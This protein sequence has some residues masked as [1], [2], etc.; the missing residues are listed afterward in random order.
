MALK[1]VGTLRSDHRDARA[2][3]EE[4]AHSPRCDNAATR[5]YHRF[6]FEVEAKERCHLL[7]ATSMNTRPLSRVTGYTSKSTLRPGTGSLSIVSR[8][9]PVMSENTCLYT[10]EAIVGTASREPVIPRDITCA[11]EKGHRFCTAWRLPSASLNS[12]T[13]M[14]SISAAT[15]SSGVRRS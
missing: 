13:W 5:D 9:S 6:V 10:G 8:H 2:L 3:A 4:P 7:P 11:P 15:P 1:R 14:P 12:A